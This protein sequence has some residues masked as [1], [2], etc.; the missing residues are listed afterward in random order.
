M[1]LSAQRQSS[2]SV[3]PVGRLAMIATVSHCHRM[4]YTCDL[5]HGLMCY[6]SRL[7]VPC[8]S[9]LALGES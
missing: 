2:S 7:P 6:Q 8:G 9:K 3:R 1:M 5:R 4:P